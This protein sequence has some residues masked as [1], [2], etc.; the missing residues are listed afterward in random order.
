M[1]PASRMVEPFPV[2]GWRTLVGARRPKRGSYQHFHLPLTHAGPFGA[3]CDTPFHGAVSV[4]TVRTRQSSSSG[5]RP[6]APALDRAQSKCEQHGSHRDGSDLPGRMGRAGSTRPGARLASTN[7][8]GQRREIRDSGRESPAPW[9]RAHAPKK[10]VDGCSGSPWT[11][12][13]S[14][15][16]GSITTAVKEH[17]TCVCIQ[18]SAGLGHVKREER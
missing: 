5:S 11:D 9:W 8:R 3:A 1:S 17:T 10:L 2:C 6:T 14:T 7:T 15:P 13:G 4:S 16:A 12:A 18:A